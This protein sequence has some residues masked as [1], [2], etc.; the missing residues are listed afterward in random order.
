MANI[1]DI[2]ERNKFLKD[3]F[4]NGIDNF[5]IGQIVFAVGDRIT[6]V[7]HTHNKPNIEVAKWGKWGENY[8]ILFKGKDWSIELELQSLIFQGN[9]TYIL[10]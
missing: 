9:S 5:F 2:I 1:I 7:L 6:L 4:P 3:L 10:E 8:N